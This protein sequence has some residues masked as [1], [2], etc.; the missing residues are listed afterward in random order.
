MS[1]VANRLHTHRTNTFSI[2]NKA[3]ISYVYN[4]KDLAIAYGHLLSRKDLLT[5][6][7]NFTVI[8]LISLTKQSK[9]NTS[10]FRFLNYMSVLKEV[11]TT[12]VI[13]Y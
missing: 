2:V 4:S 1:F 5:K 8:Y 11:I 13:T 10:N 9:Q 6:L 3:Y 12:A 7:Y